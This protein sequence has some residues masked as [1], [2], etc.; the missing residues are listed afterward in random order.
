MERGPFK[1]PSRRPGARG[2]SSIPGPACGALPRGEPSPDPLPGGFPHA[3]SRP[4]QPRGGGSSLPR[5]RPPPPSFQRPP[6]LPSYSPL[7]L[8]PHPS[9]RLR[10]EA[11]LRRG[12]LHAGPCSMN[13]APCQG[14][15]R[16]RSKAHEPRGSHLER[17]QRNQK[18]AIFLKG[19]V[20]RMGVP[21][22][23]SMGSV[24]FGTIFSKG[25]Q[26]TFFKL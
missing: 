8:L 13:P 9:V 1:R 12:R 22:V 14:R 18:V 15:K 3:R 23:L 17:G 24:F 6:H 4:A 10:P 19:D 26:F 11:R 2:L 20:Y 25:K 16:L 21:V 7:S 5:C